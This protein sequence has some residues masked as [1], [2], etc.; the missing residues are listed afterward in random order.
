MIWT[1]VKQQA[2]GRSRSK[3]QIN[4]LRLI[5]CRGGVTLTSAR[6]RVTP[7]AAEWRRTQRS[8]RQSTAIWGTAGDAKWREASRQKGNISQKRWDGV[9][10]SDGASV[11]ST[12]GHF[13]GSR[14]H[15]WRSQTIVSVAACSYC[16]MFP[17]QPRRVSLFSLSLSLSLS[18]SHT[19]TH[20]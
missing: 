14:C 18:L 4:Q 5:S 6:G 13:A 19:H 11:G 20:Q 12:A 1:G 10:G 15:I 8:A 16:A 3:Q 9:T 17:W 7:H 2:E